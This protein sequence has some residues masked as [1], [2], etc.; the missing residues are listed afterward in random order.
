MAVLRVKLVQ[1]PRRPPWPLWTVALVLAWAVAI[2]GVS[3]LAGRHGAPVQLC[4]F[5]RLTGWPCPTCGTGRGAMSILRGDVLSAWRL[6]PLV[7]TVLAVVWLLLVVRVAFA[8]AVRIEWTRAAKIAAWV[9]GVAA[10][11]LNW[12]YVIAFVG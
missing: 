4:L 6:N 3:W 1:V 12:A 10:V 7:F 11:L 5:K 8:R 9:V 2:G